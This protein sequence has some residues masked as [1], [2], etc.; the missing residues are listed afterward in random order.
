MSIGLIVRLNGA[1]P[2]LVLLSAFSFE[3]AFPGLK[4]AVPLLEANNGILVGTAGEPFAPIKLTVV[5][6]HQ[7][8]APAKPELRIEGYQGCLQGT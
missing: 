8:Q 2:R 5:K 6:P 1:R 3:A 4:H 7:K